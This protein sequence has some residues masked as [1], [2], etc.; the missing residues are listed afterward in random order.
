MSAT[1]FTTGP[2][3]L[4]P[5]P[6]ETAAGTRDSVEVEVQDEEKRSLS[7]Q[8]MRHATT[9]SGTLQVAVLLQMPSPPSHTVTESENEI[10]VR[11]EL[12]I[13]LVEAPWT[14][15]HPSCSREGQEIT[16]S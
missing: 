14:T 16:I 10:G 15:E 2:P 8:Q 9:S 12:A 4:G 11:G 3:G 13:G 1:L 7:V 5:G 6:V